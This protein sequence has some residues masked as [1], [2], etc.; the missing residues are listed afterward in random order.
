MRRADR[1]FQII[2]ILR[3]ERRPVT[4]AVMAV[5]LETSLRTVY[6]D[7][8]DLIG[9]RVPIRGEAGM[10]YVLEGGFDLPPLMLTPDEIEAVVL[11]AQWV[12]RRGDPSLAQAA[13]DLIAKI[14]ACVPD[15]LL[16]YIETPA[17]GAPPRWEGE[18]AGFVLDL[19][20]TRGQIRL[21]RKIALS[22]RDQE[23]RP[24]ERVIWPVIIGYTDAT[25]ILVG[26]CELRQ[27]FR[28][29]RADR[30]V[31]VRF[32]DDRYPDRPA[33]L[34]ARWRKTHVI[35]TIPAKTGVHA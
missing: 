33:A 11:G 17:V 10:G 27:A 23:G 16:P 31:E 21:G 25:R 26:W 19:A 1:L 6:R 8:A 15:H 5:E 18:R 24:T 32:L 22:Y 2:Q 7:I 3:R 4:G 28:S 35:P 12:A 9:Q 34:Q 13:G 29:F 20:A 14:A 30:I